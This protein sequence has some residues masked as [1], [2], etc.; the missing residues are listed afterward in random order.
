MTQWGLQVVKGWWQQVMVDAAQ[1]RLILDHALA[2]SRSVMLTPCD[3]MDC[4][5]PGSS[6]H[7]I[8]L[9]RNTGVGC[10]FLLQGIFLTQGWNLGLLPCGQIL[11]HVSPQQSPEKWIHFF[12]FYVAQERRFLKVK[13]KSN[14]R[15]CKSR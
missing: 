8:S 11:Y 7:G 6:V 14:F 5:P 3:P 15:R 13:M 12:P 10:H 2:L 1:K 4:S 9:G